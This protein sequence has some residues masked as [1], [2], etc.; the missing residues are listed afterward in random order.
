[1]GTTFTGLNEALISASLEALAYDSYK[2][3]G[4]ESG[5]AK[6]MAKSGFWFQIGLAV[7]TFLVGT[8]YYFSP[9]LPY[10][11]HTV[12]VLVSVVITFFLIELKVDSVQFTLKNYLHQIKQGTKEAFKTKATTLISL[13]YIA[14]AGITW[15]NQM[16]FNSFMLVELGFGDQ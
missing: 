2:Q 7:G 1:M 13:Y 14:V 4:E 10:I 3:D 6:L 16:Y 11:V 9:V 12:F 8:L 5:F 15:T